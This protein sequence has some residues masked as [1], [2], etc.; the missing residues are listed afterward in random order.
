[1]ANLDA[2]DS[3]LRETLNLR[4]IPDYP[5]ALNG[6]QLENQ[7]SVTKIAAA[8]D[9]H[10][11]VVE[12]AIAEEADLLLVH[13]GLFWSGAK[14][15]C[16][17]L[18]QKFKMAIDH[19]LAIYSIHI[20]LDEH[21]ELGNNALLGKA[22]GLKNPEPFMPWKGRTLGLRFKT[23]QSRDSLVTKLENAIGGPVN[24]CP[25]GPKQCRNVGIITGGGGGEVA[26][27]ANLGVDTF[28]T[29]EGQ[30]WTFTLAEELGIN[31]LYG[32]HYATETF[33]VRALAEHLAKQF[34][35]EWTFVDHPTGL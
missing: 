23:N 12:K 6:L 31:L 19:N 35:L 17:A 18:Y 9:A 27:A 30:H 24:V 4:Q 21:P 13:H 14:P 33:G 34:D 22:I 26:T 8:V 2:L 10:L 25:G 7:G 1:M 32:G 16:G 11:P 5:N 15:I 29:G 20:P 3:Y 28:I